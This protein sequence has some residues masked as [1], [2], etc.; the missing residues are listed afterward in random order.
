[1]NRDRQLE[2][3]KAATFIGK[4]AAFLGCLLCGLNFSWTKEIPTAAVTTNKQFMWNPDFFD[5]LS[6]EERKFVLLHE[7]WHIALLHGLRCGNREHRRWVMACDYRINAN[8]IKDGYTMPEGGLFSEAY[9]DPRISEEDIYEDLPDSDD[10]ESQS[11]GSNEL[12]LTP[13]EQT[14]LVQAALNT[15]GMAG[16]VPGNAEKVF[17]DFLKPKLNWRVLLHRYLLEMIEPDY[18]WS[19]PNRRFRDVYLPSLLPQ[20]GR[21]IAIALFLDTSGS[22]TDEQTQRFISEAKFIQENL[23]PEKLIVVQFDT[24]IQEEKI[25]TVDKPFKN[26]IIKGYGGTDYSPVREYILKHKPTLSLIFTDLDADPI[27]DIGKNRVLWITTSHR[28]A[29][30]GE[31]IRVEE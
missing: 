12:E 8:L 10:Y 7:L 5:S 2:Q 28:I 18:S 24:M 25:Y 26:I 30:V 17:K 27:G 11:W 1:M 9:I 13:S 3:V 16:D 23:M 14:S 29:K 15:A 4:N 31:T 21:L 20:E 22:I 6:F 19:K